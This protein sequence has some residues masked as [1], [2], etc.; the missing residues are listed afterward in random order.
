VTCWAYYPGPDEVGRAPEELLRHSIGV[1]EYMF[2]DLW[3]ITAPVIRKASAMLGVSEGLVG[4]AVLLAG[5]LHDLGKAC[6][7]YQ[8]KPWEGFS[9]HWLLSA[10]IV[11][12]IITNPKYSVDTGMGEDEPITLVS[13]FVLPILLH[14][15][16]QTDLLSSVWSTNVGRVQVHNDCV[17]ALENMVDYG[18]GRAKSTIGRGILDALLSDLGDNALTTQPMPGWV[19][20]LLTSNLFDPRRLVTMVIA[21][22]LNEADG[23][24]AGR[25][26]NR[27]W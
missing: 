19:R 4:D 12:N 11:Y 6:A 27:G 20:N 8:E 10:G 18:L 15:Y 9:G 3:R 21:G 16:A 23:T 24:V 7:C 14:H 25:N 2:N 1:V 26:R 17:G 13:L 5:L 22:L